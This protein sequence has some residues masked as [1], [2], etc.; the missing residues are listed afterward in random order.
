MP[1]PTPY[2]WLGG[3]EVNMRCCLRLGNVLRKI[4]WFWTLAYLFCTCWF[5]YQLVHIL[6]NYLAPTLTNTEVK[7]VPLKSMDFPLDIKICFQSEGLNETALKSF[8]YGDSAFGYVYGAIDLNDS[9]ALI[10]WGGNQSVGVK[11]A[12]EILNA[13]KYDWTLSRVFNTFII[14]SELETKSLN[15]TLLRI[16]WVDPCYFLNTDVIGENYQR[17]QNSNPTLYFTFDESTMIKRNVSAELKLQGRNLATGRNIISHSFYHN[18]DSIK[19]DTFSNFRVKIKKKVFI[20][21]EP[22]T[23]CRNYPSSDFL[24]YR[25]CD[26]HYMRRRVDSFAPGLNLTP[27]WMTDDLSKV[28]TK[29]VVVSRNTWRKYKSA[30]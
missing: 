1:S 21:G 2:I 27:V 6:P 16:N 9:H 28:T 14:W 11:N 19:L 29:P 20:E 30:I 23:T 3:K 10:G 17:S 18:G 4:E 5:L 15:I 24:S 25:D 8:G 26:D 13:A 7:E 22:G 12:S